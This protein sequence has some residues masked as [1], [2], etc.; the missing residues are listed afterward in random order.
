MSFGSLFDGGAGGGGGG[1]GMQF[2][3]S[4]GFSSSPAL[5]LGLVRPALSA[6]PFDF[7]SSSLPPRPTTQ[8]ALFP[9]TDLLFIFIY[10]LSEMKWRC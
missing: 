10:F 9:A 5:S 4:G 1:G 7:D 2:P 6:R 8:T 3:F